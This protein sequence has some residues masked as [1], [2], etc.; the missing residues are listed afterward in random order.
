MK[1]IALLLFALLAFS[2]Q[3]HAVKAYPYPVSVTQPDGSKLTIRIFG[4]ENRSWQTTLD[5]RPVSQGPDGFWRIIDSLPPVTGRVKLLNPEGGTLS[6]FLATKAP[7]QVRT[8]VIP[9]QFR[10][11]KFTVPSPRSAI[12]NLFNQQY[13][14]ENGATGSVLDWFRDNLGTSAGFSFDVC[15][16]VTVPYDAAWYGANADGVTDVNLPQ[17][18]VHACEAADAAGVDFT[19]YDFDKDGIVDNVFLLFA[20][21]N[22][23]EG[24]GDATL[25]PQSWN[26][27]D[28]GLSLDGMRISNFSLYSEYSGPSGYRFAGIGTI[29]HEY[30]HFLG[31]PDLY[32]VNGDKEGESAGL[33]GTLSIMDQGNYN[34]E[35]RTPPYLTIFERQLLSLVKTQTLRQEQPLQIGPVQESAV[36][37]LL[38]TD[39]NGEDFWLEY[40]D[41][42]KWDAYIGGAGLVVYHIDKSG[43]AAGSMS[44]RMRWATNAV[45]ACEVHPCATYVASDGGTPNRVE[46]AFY[47][48]MTN[49]RSIHSAVNF[50]L[51]AWS[52]RGIGYGLTG[53]VREADGI[54]CQVVY[55]QS[56]DLPA[57][58][59]WSIFPAQTSA[60]LE[61]ECDKTGTGQWNLRWGVVNGVDETTVTLGNKHSYLFENLTPGESYFCELYYTHWNVTGKV[62]RMEFRALNRLSD[63][64]L[65]GGMD[66]SWKTGDRFRLFLLNLADDPV[67]VS[68]QINSEACEGEQYTFVKAGS[69]KIVA[70]ITYSDGSKET[71][72][73]IVEVKDGQ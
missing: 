33:S 53:I 66:R 8:I 50:P 38:P 39:Q 12:Y 11:R 17:L 23:A 42:S 62:Y 59:D 36:A 6:M 46:T 57:V 22:E 65:I 37:W 44:A 26:I 72:T 41:G 9:V 71:L 35:G 68:W 64:P 10:D 20:G 34:N 43:S 28:M 19:R 4:D 63:Y 21:H 48:G 30:C 52:G 2:L 69:Y 13:Y 47:P 3:L 16:V 70:T 7:V 49:V 18:V 40:R 58:T 15:D 55:D 51:R 61:W 5:G 32:D 45:N 60:L 24:G 14:S 73:K 54:F 56:W 27:A 67:S 29:C 31:L 1:R 25:W